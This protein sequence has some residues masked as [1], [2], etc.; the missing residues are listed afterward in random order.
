MTQPFGAPPDSHE[1][2]LRLISERFDGMSKTYQSI[3]G[4]LTR[5]PNEVAVQSVNAI[6]AACGIHPSSFVR[7]AQSLGFSGFKQVQKLF[8][9][10]LSV[11]APGHDRPDA[12]WSVDET[13]GPVTP[14]GRSVL[15][16]IAALRDL[17]GRISQTDMQRAAAWIAGAGTVYL[18][19]RGPAA[20]L[21]SL[22]SLD[23]TLQGRRSVSLD[24]VPGLAQHAAGAMTPSD[25]LIV[26]ALGDPPSEVI[27]TAASGAQ[28]GLPVIA[29]SDDMLSPL[30]AHATVL[31]P[32]PD[33]SDWAPHSLAA[34]GCLVRALV[35][36]AREDP[37]S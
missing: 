12:A 22:L 27:Q 33:Q 35:A 14:L 10:R 34:P 26:A 21:V 36:M 13:G 6:G 3:A 30:R 18:I 28:A 4:Y 2:L 15:R 17:M 25:V 23:L 16:D 20:P 11:V 29:V 7:F 24:A 8:Q 5:H 32:L 31:F 9:Q 19:G 37:A 1:A